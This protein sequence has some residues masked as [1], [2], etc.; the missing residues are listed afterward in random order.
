MANILVISGH[1]RLDHSNAN[2]VIIKKLESSGLDLSVLY[3]HKGGYTFDVPAAQE[4]LR[5]AKAVVFQFPIFWY[6][7][8]SLMKKWVEDV[9]AHGFAYGSQGTALKGK[10]FFISCTTGG[11]EQAYRAEGMQKHTL[12]EFFYNFD[13]IAA[14]CGMKLH[15]PFV[16]YGCA[17]V[18]GMSP[19]SV[20]E[21]IVK[22]AENHADRLILELKKI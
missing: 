12:K 8:P 1:P 4:A 17:Y 18:P 13:Q 3:L 5:E 21:R 20:K 10:D 16:T 7:Y 6:S 15:E 14:L 9:F 2:A 19:G 22:E 11:P